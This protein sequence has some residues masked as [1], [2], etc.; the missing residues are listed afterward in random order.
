[1]NFTWFKT[2]S[3][4]AIACI[5]SGCTSG[6]LSSSGVES[7]DRLSGM[8]SAGPVRNASVKVYKLNSNGSQGDLIGTAT[9]DANGKYTLKVTKSHNGPTMIVASGGSYEEEASGETV[10][11]GLAQIRTSLPSISAKQEIGITPIT[12]IATQNAIANAKVN[13]SIELKSLIEVSNKQIAVAMGVEDITEPPSDPYSNAKNAKTS[14]AATYSVVLGAISQMSSA[15]SVDGGARVNSLDVA[16]ALATSFIYNGGKFDRKAKVK[17][18][19]AD[20][21][22]TTSTSSNMTLANVLAASGGTGA[23]FS[24]AMNEAKDLYLEECGRRNLDY[25]DEDIV[26]VPTFVNHPPLPSGAPVLNEPPSPVILPAISPTSDGPPPLPPKPTEVINT[27]IMACIPGMGL[28]LAGHD[29]CEVEH[30][31]ATGGKICNAN[32]T[33][34]TLCGIGL[35]D[36]GYERDILESIGVF[37]GKSRSVFYQGACVVDG[38]AQNPADRVIESTESE[39]VDLDNTPCEPGVGAET[40]T[41]CSVANSSAP[42]AKICNANGTGYTLCAI[43]YCNV[44]FVKNQLEQTGTYQGISTSVGYAGQCSAASP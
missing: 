41:S 39:L 7:G 8:V 20:V 6:F 38:T 43:A 12:E 35:C 10:N 33:G 32:G 19:Q 13:A 17:S 16:Q 30:G 34:Y 5:I 42:G 18:G 31:G 29:S 36:D 4:F 15:A 2:T 3:I 28:S 27:N 23:S 9:T 22:V 24:D 14:T 1:M 11:L 40:S 21:P 44:G 25:E 26:P 37:Q